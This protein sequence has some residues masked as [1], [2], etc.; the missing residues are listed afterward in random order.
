MAPSPPQVLQPLQLHP[1]TEVIVRSSPSKPAPSPLPS[2]PGSPTTAMVGI[3]GLRSLFCDQRVL[4]DHFFDHLDIAPVQKFAKVS[5]AV[6]QALLGGWWAESV[7]CL[8]SHPEPT[9]SAGLPGLQ[10]HHPLHRRRQERLR[11]A[12]ERPTCGAAPRPPRPTAAHT[13]T[14]THAHL[15]APR[16]PLPPSRAPQK[17]SQTLVSTGVRAAFLCSQASL[18]GDLGAV[19]A[20]DLVCLFS[21]SGA[22]E[23]LLRLVSRRIVSC[24]T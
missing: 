8:H 21:K 23:E 20:G 16:S 13:H 22:T 6:G 24:M 1:A 17:I 11:G 5:P 14:H 2:P 4:L 9:R 18:H 15:L 19:N 10:G 7:P 3:D 12:G